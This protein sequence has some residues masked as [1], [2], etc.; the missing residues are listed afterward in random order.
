MR[1]QV[2]IALAPQLDQEFRQQVLQKILD[3]LNK[4]IQ[5]EKYYVQEGWYIQALITLA[6]QLD[7]KCRQNMLQ[8][9]WKTAEQIWDKL[10]RAHVLA[11]LASQLAPQLNEEPRQELLLQV[12][13]SAVTDIQDN[14]KLYDQV[15]TAWIPQLVGNSPWPEK[16]LNAALNFKG[17]ERIAF[18]ATLIQNNPNLLTYALWTNWLEHAP[19]KRPELFEVTDKLCAAAIQLTGNP[20]EANEIAKAVMDVAKWWP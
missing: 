15:L 18:S 12:W 10:R 17:K 9:A 6:P 7:P 14:E 20:Q 5:Y 3:I 8:R 13:N 11:V 4:Y 16:F 1:A 2:L 19:L